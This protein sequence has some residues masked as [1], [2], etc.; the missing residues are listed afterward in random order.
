[1]K[2]QSKPKGN[3]HTELMEL[4]QRITEMDQLEIERSRAKYL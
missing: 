2:D 4:H 1:M 3:D